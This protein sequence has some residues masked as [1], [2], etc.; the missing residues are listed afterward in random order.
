MAT[1]DVDCTDAH[2]VS[3]RSTDP[4][5]KDIALRKCMQEQ[6]KPLASWRAAL[7]LRL[8]SSA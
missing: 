4:K 6:R 8:G 5:N 1:P 2:S 3:V 7:R